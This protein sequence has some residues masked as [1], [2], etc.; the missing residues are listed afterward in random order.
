[1]AERVVYGLHAV[2]RLLKSSPERVIEVYLQAGI[3]RKRLARLPGL[4]RANVSECSDE[5]LEELTGTHKHQGVAA[6]ISATGFLTDDEA[7]DLLESLGNPL[8]LILDSVQ[9]PRNFGAC[10][11]SAD[12]AGADLVVIGR[13]RNVGLTPVVSKVAAGAAEAQPVASVGNLARFMKMLTEQGIRIVGLADEAGS[14]LFDC[15]LDGPLALVLGAEGEGLRRLTRERC[16]LLAY[17]PMRGAVESL[18]VSVAA[19]ICLYEAQRRRA[20][21]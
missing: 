3:G 2:G 21:G 5:R 4:S 6:R 18:N 1:M 8:I 20:P 15:E 19:G 17:L 14:S 12:G 9:D 16:D 7:W 13:S 10:L 11:R